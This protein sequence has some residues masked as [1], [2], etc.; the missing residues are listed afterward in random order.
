MN[1]LG[2]TTGWALAYFG[3]SALSLGM[4]RHHADIHG[5]GSVLDCR[6]RA[7]YRLAGFLALAACYL[8]NTHSEGWAVGLLSCLG[9]MTVAA[10]PL[11]LLL[12]YAPQRTASLGKLAGLL[13]ISIGMAWVAF[14]K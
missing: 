2:F 3:W 1:M 4:D 12:A 7:R 10:L 11:A 13:A 6:W 5:R 14:V 9:T 8:V